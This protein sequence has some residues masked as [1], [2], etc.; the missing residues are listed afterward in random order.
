MI[1]LFLNFKFWLESKTESKPKEQRTLVSKVIL[2]GLKLICTYLAFGYLQVIKLLHL[3]KIDEL[4]DSDELP[5]VSLTTFPKR[6]PHLWMV[7]FCVFKQTVRP[8]KIV[9][10]LIEDEIPN[11]IASLPSIL[12]Y[13]ETK[14]VEFLF[15]K[16]NLRPHNKYF[17]C[18]Q[19]YPERIIVT[20]DDDLLYYSHTIKKLLQMHEKYPNCVC[21]NRCCEIRLNNKH[22]ASYSEW[23][24]VLKPKGPAKDI[25]ALGYA[26]VLYP[27]H[28]FSQEYF[29]ISLIKAL[30]LRTD[31]LW[32]KAME[33][34]EGINIVCGEYY[35]HPM[36]LPSSQT[37]ALQKNNCAKENNGND[38]NWD[39][40]NNRL[41]LLEYFV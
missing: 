25:V 23:S 20:I 36:T 28:C 26:A 32:L 1:E 33:I 21:A 12:R 7:L 35:A 41:G 22:F 8:G 30:S 13:F 18:M 31:D 40:I 24:D 6:L 2:N 37:I 16:E 38:I 5:V 3:V 17:Y 15:A 11:G 27:A 9:V 10:T 19:K 39:R 14:G 29:D 34:K 4:E